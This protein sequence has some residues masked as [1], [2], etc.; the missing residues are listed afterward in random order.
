M[1]D[2]CQMMMLQSSQEIALQREEMKNEMEMHHQEMAMHPDLLALQ[3]Q[4]VNMVM[5]NMM[6]QSSCSN[7][8]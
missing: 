1:K 5:M 8:W 6:Q 3:Q 4:M 2:M 7:R